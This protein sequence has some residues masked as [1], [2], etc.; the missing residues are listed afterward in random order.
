MAPNPPNFDLEA[1][2]AQVAA[3]VMLDLEKKQ[4]AERQNDLELSRK[5]RIDQEKSKFRQPA[6]K[7]AVGFIMELQY[8]MKDFMQS[9]TKLFTE[10]EEL[11][12]IANNVEAV[13]AFVKKCSGFGNKMNRK[14]SREMEAYNVAN[15]SRY[16]WA[17]EKF[18]RQED[19]FSKTGV[20]QEETKWYE[21]DEV[22]PEEKVKKLRN[23]ERQVALVNKQKKPFSSKFEHRGRKRTRWGLPPAETSSSST[24]ASS[25][26]SASDFK[27]VPQ[28]QQYHPPAPVRQPPKCYKCGQF[29]HIQMYCPAGQIKKE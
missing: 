22:S 21:K 12:P 28:Q 24:L 27:V 9:F 14:L 15:T 3:K 20:M 8:D 5:L 13:E 17:A 26:A 23:A 19:L 2:Q 25:S 11:K 7:R 1:F 10:G 29:G 4:E 18:F 6:D 16:G